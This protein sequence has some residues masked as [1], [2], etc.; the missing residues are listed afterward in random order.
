MVV[1]YLCGLF[2]N[3]SRGF[4]GCFENLIEGKGESRY[5]LCLSFIVFGKRKRVM[6]LRLIGRKKGMTQ[7]FDEKGQ[8]VPCTVIHVEPNPVVQV[9][10]KEV[11]GYSALQLGGVGLSKSR[12]ANLTKPLKGHLAKANASSWRLKETRIPDASAYQIGQLIDLSIFSEVHYVDVQGVSK[13]KGYQG[14]MK[15]HGFSGGPAAHGSGFHRHAGS[16]GQRTTPGRCYPGGKRASRMGGD[17]KTVQSL[18]V[19]AIK[20]DFLLVE[21]AV[22]GPKEGVVYITKAL[23]R[24]KA[25]VSKAKGK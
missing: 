23:K 5:A 3:G 6:S 19:V 21:G 2:C 1:S 8:I 15:L 11:D 18:R 13:G 9:K 22:P 14:V 4:H 12:A 7:I 24:Q 20:G 25:N 16:T 17:V 10:S